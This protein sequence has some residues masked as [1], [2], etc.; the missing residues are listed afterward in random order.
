MDFF[1][2]TSREA[3]RELDLDDLGASR[4]NMRRVFTTLPPA[5][6]L[7]AL[8]ALDARLQGPF[9]RSQARE[10]TRLATLRAELERR[11]RALVR[12]GS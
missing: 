10:V 6:R 2:Q 11:H 1:E 8:Q 5:R 12:H 9:E 3:R 7:A 4:D